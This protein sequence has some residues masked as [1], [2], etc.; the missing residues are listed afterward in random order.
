MPEVLAG[1]TMMPFVVTSGRA[2]GR[3]KSYGPSM[4]HIFIVNIRR[5]WPQNHFFDETSDSLPSD[6][7]LK[8]R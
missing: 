1:V 8:M 5:R 2:G 7:R 6:L 3:S 4:H